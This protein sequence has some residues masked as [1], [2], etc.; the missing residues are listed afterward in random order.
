MRPYLASAVLRSRF[1][2]APP[3]PHTQGSG[4]SGTARGMRSNGGLG[5]RCAG[6]RRCAARRAPPC[7]GHLA[8]EP[9]RVHS[10]VRIDQPA[11][12]TQRHPGLPAGAAAAASTRRQLPPFGGTNS[13][14][15][16]P[17]TRP[18]RGR[19]PRLSRRR[20]LTRMP[21]YM[22]CT[23]WSATVAASRW[24]PALQGRRCRQMQQQAR[25]ADH[26]QSMT[27]VPEGCSPVLFVPVGASFRC[28]HPAHQL[29]IRL[30]I[31]LLPRAARAT[32]MRRRRCPPPD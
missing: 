16:S 4:E 12:P 29:L 30:L 23:L 19:V 31:L 28:T 24:V 3:P 7:P 8:T 25:L 1:R 6:R 27:R 32:C 21:A 26:V 17:P 14:P 22:T 9:V 2:L 10:W 13:G 11:S 20:Q 15:L 18:R 5:G